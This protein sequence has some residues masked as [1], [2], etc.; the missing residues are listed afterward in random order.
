M[1]LPSCR[2]IQKKFD[3]L[4]SFSNRRLKVDLY[5][6]SESYSNLSTLTYIMENLIVYDVV[7]DDGE[8]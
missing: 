5:E 6:H 3:Y 1:K 8:N 2:F 4:L 7:L